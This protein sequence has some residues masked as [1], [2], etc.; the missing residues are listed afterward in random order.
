MEHMTIFIGF[1]TPSA[2]SG[3]H[4]FIPQEWNLG[5]Y[6]YENKL[7]TPFTATE[8]YSIPDAERTFHFFYRNGILWPSWLTFDATRIP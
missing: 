8:H 4:N 3:I 5:I 2:G 1:I 7:W 6:T